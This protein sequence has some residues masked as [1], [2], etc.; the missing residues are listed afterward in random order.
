M[1]PGPEQNEELKIVNLVVSAVWG[2]FLHT[3]QAE[4]LLEKD[5]TTIV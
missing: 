5:F 3:K 4:E 1:F 2:G